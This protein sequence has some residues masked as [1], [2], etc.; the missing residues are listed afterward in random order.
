MHLRLTWS[1]N[2][3]YVKIKFLM[4][5]LLLH[6]RADLLWSLTLW[7]DKWPQFFIPPCNYALCTFTLTLKLANGMWANIEHTDAL[8]VWFATVASSIF[9]K[10]IC[11]VYRGRRWDTCSTAKLHQLS[12][13][14][15]HRITHKPAS[16]LY[17]SES[18]Q[19]Q[20][21]HSAGLQTYELNK[22]WLS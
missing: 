16:S 2:I 1:L 11:Q 5:L 6:S 3:F 15:P 9:V 21:N 10:K 4:W 14:K 7:N 18:S 22:F 20:K 12:Q 8:K 17:E 19:D 13:L